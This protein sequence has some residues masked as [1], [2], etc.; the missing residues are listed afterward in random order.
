MWALIAPKGVGLVV[1]EV[2]ENPEVSGFK[3]QWRKTL[4]DSFHLAYPWWKEL[5]GTRCLKLVEVRG[6]DTTVIKREDVCSWFFL[7][8]FGL[9]MSDVTPNH[10]LSIPVVESISGSRPTL[11]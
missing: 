10:L 7:F 9:P 5:P 4:G 3:T 8:H 6:P 11:A 1:N 2:V